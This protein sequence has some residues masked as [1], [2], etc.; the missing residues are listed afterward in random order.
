[1]STPTKAYP[2]SLLVGVQGDGSPLGTV[3]T[4]NFAGADVS[5]VGDVATVSAGAVSATGR[6]ISRL[7]IDCINGN[8]IKIYAG[9]SVGADS[10]DFVI[11]VPSDL[12]ANQAVAGP[13]PNGR[14]QAGAFPASSRVYVWL[15]SNGTTTASLLSLSYT[16]PTLPPTY[17][18]KRL[19]GYALMNGASFRYFWQSDR[20]VRLDNRMP[21]WSGVLGTNYSAQNIVTDGVPI[22]A[23][24]V[25]IGVQIISTDGTPRDIWLWGRPGI[26][27]GAGA[28]GVLIEAANNVMAGNEHRT[29]C[30]VIVPIR[31][32]TISFYL[33]AIYAG[34]SQ[35][36]WFTGYF[37]NI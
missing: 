16:T 33:S 27:A 29:V 28:G 21:S 30:D 36:C 22:F 8:Q 32:Q 31:D 23:S 25:F 5:V 12:T 14:D 20:L 4:F 34:V 1:M 26:W 7:M 13:T 35:S 15:I 3:N 10:G 24:D 6:F 2:H 37:L 19:V 18:K 9:A 17:T 11:D